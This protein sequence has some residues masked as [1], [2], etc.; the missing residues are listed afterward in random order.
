MRKPS[1]I[2][3]DPP[4]TGLTSSLK[5]LITNP[6]RFG[7][8]NL[9]KALTPD[10]RMAAATSYLADDA[11][12]RKRLNR[13]VARAR[14]F[15]PATVQRWPEEKVV[16]AIRH[17]PL[18]DDLRVAEPLLT[19]Y[20]LP[21]QS[22]MV[23]AFMNGLGVSH[24]QGRVE[25]LSVIDAKDDVVWSA[26]R[27]IV[28]QFGLR[29]A[30]VYLLTLRLF[31]APAGRAGRAWLQKLL[32]APDAAAALEVHASAATEE[33]AVEDDAEE[34]QPEQ[35][36]PTRQPSFTTL[37]RLLIL[38]AVDTAQGIEGALSE[39]Q[40]DDVVDELVKLNG[41]HHQSYF[42]AGLRDVL[43]DK[44]I[45]EDVPAANPSLLRWYWTGAV[46]GWARRE[47]W[48]R[49]VREHA[50]NPVIRELGN[51][52]TEPSVAAVRHI[53]EALRRE[54]QTTDIAQFVKVRA[55]VGQPALFEL[56]LDAA[57]ELLGKGDAPKALPLFEL[58][59]K[60]RRE[61]ERRGVPPTER[62][63]LDAHRRMAHC[64]RHLHQHRRARRLLGD[65]LKQD[66]DP[67]I[68][69]MV[70]ADLGLLAGG[71]DALEEVV[72]PLRHDELAS[73]LERLA[74]GF[75]HFQQ[76]VDIDT[77]YSAHGHYCL[78]VLALGRAVGDR[79]FKDA[80][81]HLQFTRVR[82]SETADSYSNSLVEHANLYFG[83]AKAQQLSADKLAHAADVM[84]R[85]MASGARIPHYLIEQTIEA[86]AL[87]EEKEDLHRVVSAIIEEQGDRVLDEL[88]SCESALDHCPTLC[89][90]LK[91]RAQSE[92]R[93]TSAQAAD[94]RS[95]L[96]G[97]QKQGNREAAAEALDGLDKLAQDGVGVPEFLEMLE[98]R[99]LY[100]PAW[101][102]E[103]ATIARA[104]CLEAH[105]KYPEAVHVLQ[106]LFHRLA[107]REREAGLDD[108]AGVL[109]RI[110][111]YGIDPASYSSLT[112]RYNALAAQE[113]EA[114]PSL[115]G[116]PPR[117]VRVLVVGGGEEQ[118][119]AEDM[120]RR[121]LRDTDPHIRVNFIQTGWSENWRRK[122]GEIE[123]AMA[124]HDAL[125]IVR[126]MRT[127]L[128]RRIR[129][130]WTGGPWR[131][132]WG[133]GHGAIAEA[134]TRAAAAVR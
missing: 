8:I 64:L 59:M 87:P 95:A 2:P 31:G 37:D 131:S 114:A 117:A 63:L 61:L 34:D 51:G 73:F 60:T 15:R 116:E 78:G 129:E 130:R 93:T 105:G 88:A 70:H 124:R 122:F 132:C 111:G 1:S 32:E 69:A 53:A 9:W 66:P 4:Q 75:D 48:D 96:L 38:A 80:E 62:I 44:S 134:V 23:I 127:H 55:L 30:A 68:H 113:A 7:A 118:A 47:R 115:E 76:S 36:D 109:N 21:G 126:F 90:A 28:E 106:K 58:L 91:A 50:T 45:G 22:D 13:I 57:T 39:D 128:G 100:E 40:L 67:N 5:R 24:D 35:D 123:G 52:S 94:L 26:A 77:A 125:V 3:P 16:K 81:R 17:V 133:G 89:D 49:I 84:T 11:D 79:E 10:E 65:L 54:G 110:R 18:N 101:Q 43:F 19:Y 92:G 104:R 12:A 120:V 82:F 103:D 107:T 102:W 72:L 108:A 121:K 97:F 29:A 112:D 27:E 33:E 86:L 99:S 85:S 83:I 74:E 42:H 56:L 25:S 119:R 20:H 6:R 46:Q 14:N 71:F 41:R 98:H